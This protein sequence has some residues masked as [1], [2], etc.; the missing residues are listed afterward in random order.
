MRFSHAVFGL[1]ALVLWAAFP[2]RAQVIVNQQALE[3][4]GGKKPPPKHLVVPKRRVYR[5]PY[6]RIV[7]RPRP[8]LPLPP[9][10]EP[11]FTKPPPPPPPAKP[12]PPRAIVLSFSGTSTALPDGGA[13]ALARFIGKAPDKTMHYVVQAAAPGEASDPSVARRRA[14]DRGLAVR[15]V[16]RRAGIGPE[17]IIV[18]A[19][20]DPPGLPTGRVTLTETP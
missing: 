20:G 2:A 16:L 10:P 7:R 9:P 17:H 13:A 4:L 5:R 11:V 6:H 14:L 12:A 15:A 18:Q 19:L 8:P 3:Q 1:S